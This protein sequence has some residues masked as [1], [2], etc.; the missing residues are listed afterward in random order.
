VRQAARVASRR[1]SRSLSRATAR[2]R[3]RAVI[4]GPVALA[5]HR[6]RRAA[7]PRQ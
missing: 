7:W 4:A 6:A 3:D 5:E 1:H 2:V